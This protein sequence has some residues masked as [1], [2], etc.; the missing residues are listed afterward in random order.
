MMYVLFE[1]HTECT[2]KFSKIIWFL[3]VPYLFYIHFSDPLIRQKSNRTLIFYT[4]KHLNIFWH[5]QQ[6]LSTESLEYF[7]DLNLI[8]AITLTAGGKQAP[9]SPSGTAKC[10]SYTNALSKQPKFRPP[11]NLS[12]LFKM[13]E[14]WELSPDAGRENLG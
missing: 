10:Y 11:A 8:N 4:L 2:H 12:L 7:C 1:Y 5:Y 3:S 14:E 13:T 9:P 6:N